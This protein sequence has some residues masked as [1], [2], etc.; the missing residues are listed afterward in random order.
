MASACGISCNRLG[1]HFQAALGTA[2]LDEQHAERIHDG[3]LVRCQLVGLLGIGDG[4]GSFIWPSDQARL[5]SSAGS[6]GCNA[7][8]LRYCATAAA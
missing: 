3:G 6:F 8:R 5:L 7:S 2:L 4:F 1:Q